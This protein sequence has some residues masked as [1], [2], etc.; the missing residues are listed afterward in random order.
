MPTR[1]P[2]FRV[3][4]RRPTAGAGLKLRLAGVV[5]PLLLLLL[6]PTALAR[7]AGAAPLSGLLPSPVAGLLSPVV[8]L[9]PSPVTGLLSPVVG[10]VAG[11]VPAVLP[12]VCVGGVVLCGGTVVTQPTPCVASVVLCGALPLPSNPVI[13]PAQTPTTPRTPAGANPAG[14]GAPA[15]RAS[16][17]P[18]GGSVGSGG[19]PAAVAVNLPLPAPPGVGLV[20]VPRIAAGEGLAPDSFATVLSLSMRDGLGSGRN[21][22]WPWLLAAQL[23]LWTLIAGVVRFRH[24]NRSAP[25]PRP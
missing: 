23:A 12:S 24:R 4:R 13:G 18:R 19:G 1:A 5:A 10:P 6:A 21:Q 2:R 20:P 16:R 15:A 22:V 17:A 9:L 25:A 7:P 14:G 8:G 3:R 11:L